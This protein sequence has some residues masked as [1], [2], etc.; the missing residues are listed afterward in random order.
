MEESPTS[1]SCFPS[2]APP[3]FEGHLQPAQGSWQQNPSVHLEKNFGF[4][5]HQGESRRSLPAFASTVKDGYGNAHFS[6]PSM[7]SG[8]WDSKVSY[9]LAASNSIVANPISISGH[10]KMH[11][12]VN[13]MHAGHEH[14]HDEA[15]L[16]K[17]M[18]SPLPFSE[19]ENF[20]DPRNWG[21]LNV[22]VT[23]DPLKGGLAI[24]G[25][26]L[27]ASNCLANFS[28]DPGFAER[29]ARFSSFGNPGHSEPYLAG[30][31]GKDMNR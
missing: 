30:D 27:A 6:D 31:G 7:A 8:S 28:T 21:P 17:M 22:G 29:A 12:G 2:T 18:A 5:R 15:P 4:T 1:P 9:L 20:L 10:G 24:Q 23:I 25:M 3:E 14:M 19:T 16:M 26:N 11:A 13:Y